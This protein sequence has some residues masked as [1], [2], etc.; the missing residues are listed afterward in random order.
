VV[1]IAQKSNYC[2]PAAL[3]MVANYYGQPVTQDD[4]AAA[5]TTPHGTVTAELAAHAG[6]LG[7]WS[8][9]YRGSVAELRQKT[10]AGVPIIVLGKFGGNDHYFVVLSLDD[11]RKTV[12]V[13]SDTRAN[14][15]MSQEAFLRYWDRADRWT[16][17]VCPSAKATWRLTADEHNDLGVFLEKAG[18]LAPAAGHYRLAAEMSPTNSYFHLNLGNA[19]LKQRLVREAAAAYAKAVAAAPANADALNNLANAYLELGANLDEAEQHCRRAV[20]LRPSHRAYY[21]DTLGSILLKQG[22]TR[23]AVTAFEQALAAT[24]D[25][26]TALREAIRQRLK[27]AQ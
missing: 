22:N 4:I 18:Q 16:L 17:L 9:Q 1:F 26:Q 14:L 12:T 7:F 27:E 15:E 23:E 10:A 6:K 13:H 11:W 3:A 20:E 2:G 21:L 24:T 8:R 19:L 25:R 5:I